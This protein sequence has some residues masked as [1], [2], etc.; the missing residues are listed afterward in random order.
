MIGTN[1]TGDRLEDPHTLGGLSTV[2]AG[3][4]LVNGSLSG[5]VRVDA[6][7]TLGG[8][9]QIGGRITVLP[10]GTL[11]PGNSPGTLTAASLVLNAGSTL[12]IELGAPGDRLVVLDD[13]TLAGRIDFSGDPS[14]LVGSSFLSY[15]GTL[16][17]LGIVIGSLPGGLD[18]AAFVVDFSTPGMRGDGAVARSGCRRSGRRAGPGRG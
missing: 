14:K 17:D 12:A 15:G 18:P 16:L 7:A 13:V 4:L 3:T 8:G 1:N 9:G 6:G 11:S 5:D 2:Q 10:G